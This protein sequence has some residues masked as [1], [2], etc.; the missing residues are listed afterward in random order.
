M[1][2]FTQYKK[3]TPKLKKTENEYVKENILSIT[4]PF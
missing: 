3:N 2:I 1:Y 4:N